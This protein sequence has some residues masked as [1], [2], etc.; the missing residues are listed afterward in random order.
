MQEVKDFIENFTDEEEN[1][2]N[3][4][5]F[6]QEKLAAVVRQRALIGHF[7]LQGKVHNGVQR[8]ERKTK[9]LNEIFTG[10][11]ARKKTDFYAKGKK[12]K[13][14]LQMVAQWLR[15]TQHSPSWPL[16]AGP[17]SCPGDGCA[18]DEGVTW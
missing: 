3:S 10:N 7:S 6:S 15:I 18:A 13:P 16:R 8:L 4:K 12:L 1:L 9:N 5:N 11:C 2:K 17:A 14:L